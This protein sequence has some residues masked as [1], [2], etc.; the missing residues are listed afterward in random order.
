[1]R[2]CAEIYLQFAAICIEYFIW[3]LSERN[4]EF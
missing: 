4:L 2:K 1:M 3:F